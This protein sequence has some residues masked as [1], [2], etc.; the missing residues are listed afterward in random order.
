MTAPDSLL[1]ELKPIA[2]GGVGVLA[3]TFVMMTALG[4][5]LAVTAY[6]VAGRALGGGLSAM[7]AAGL[8][9]FVATLLSIKRAVLTVVR[10][11]IVRVRLGERA[12]GLLFAKLPSVVTGAA[13]RVPLA[14]SRDHAAQCRRP[15]ARR[16]RREHR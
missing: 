9:L 15:G 5:M 10:E 6:F 13:Q 14:R 12:V 4:F 2:L 8:S 1:G 16:A 11:A 3:R 7:I